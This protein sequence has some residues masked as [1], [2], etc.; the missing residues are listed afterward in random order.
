MANPI[1]Q[2]QHLYQYSNQQAAIRALLALAADGT[3]VQSISNNVGYW[4]SAGTFTSIFTPSAGAFDPRV[5]VSRDYGFF[6]TGILADQKKW[7]ST[8]GFSK[9]GIAA[10]LTAPSVAA[11]S[12]STD[13]WLALVNYTTFGLLTDSNNNIQQL[14]SINANGSNPT[15]VQHTGTSGVGGPAWAA[16]GSTTSDNGISWLNRGPVALWT[17]NTAYKNTHPLTTNFGTVAEPGVIYDPGTNSIY[18]NNNASG[19]PGTSGANRP[20]FTGING[21]IIA[22]NGGDNGTGIAWRCIN[23]APSEWQNSHAYT[24]YASGVS[25][26][27]FRNTTITEPTSAAN[28]YNSVTGAFTA[29]V[30]FQTVQTAGT[31]AA[32]GTTPPWATTAGGTTTDGNLLWQCE[33][34]KTWVAATAYTQW[35][36]NS[37]PF[38]V[39]LDTNGNYQVCF[40]SGTSGG[41]QP[42]WL[43]NYGDQTS[44]NTVIW[45]NVGP[46]LTW[47]ASTL[48]YMGAS[49]WR[50][51]TSGGSFAGATILDSNGD[52]E[53]VISSGKSETPGP[54]TW[55]GPGLKTTD[56]TVTWYNLGVAPTGSGQVTLITPTGRQYYLIFNNPNSGGASDVS[57]VSA[58]TGAISG[59]EIF[60]SQLAVSTDPQVSTKTI[61]ATADGGDQTTLFQIATI[62]NAQTTYVDTLSELLR[63][64]QPV[65]QDTDNAGVSH[66][67]F[68]N[69]PPPNGS[70]PIKYRGRLYMILGTFLFFSKSLSDMITSTGLIAGRYEEC[71]PSSYQ[72]DI[73]EN[74]EVGRGLFTDGVVLY[75]G[76]QRHIRKIQG[77]GP[78]GPNAFT[79]PEIVFNEVGIL[80]Q[81]VWQGIFLEGS[82]AGAMWLTP[83]FRCIRSDF[84]TYSNAGETIQTTL[85][86]INPAAA[87]KSWATYVGQGGYNFYVLAIPTGTNNFPDTLC[88]YNIATG[89][90]FI[91]TPADLMRC[92]LY[93]ANLTGIPRWLVNTLDGS[94]YLFDPTM[95]MDRQTTGDRVGITTTIRT[96]FNDLTDSTLR[97]ALNEIEV[98]TTQPL[99][100]TV[101]GAS[102]ESTFLSP[103]V[104]VSGASLIQNIFGDQKLYLTGLPSFDRL[105]R[106]TFQDT[107]TI[108]SSINDV[109]L[110]YYSMEAIPLH[111]N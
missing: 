2:A 77:D 61:L 43:T 104:V 75:I 39:I 57:P 55:S 96:S 82:P 1:I 110:S 41:S 36:G 40:Q 42:T 73:S 19:N 93:Y 10:P 18:F 66:G 65:W 30:F 98:A 8:F 31:S 54:P 5:V 88:V 94:I 37:Q 38:S 11:T 28:A 74:T 50:I 46:A 101:E 67:V 44:D 105:Y 60:L 20:A 91:W 17:P 29:T 27:N 12:G 14:Q 100:L 64:A 84:N 99:T 108:N 59:G 52:L 51:P 47:A 23:P 9:W 89:R 87:S 35:L 97:K 80:N 68:F 53:S 16:P 79:S 6:L 63:E 111:R 15:P 107:S 69:D 58:G 72:L 26:N 32:S 85:N 13:T 56:G 33:G 34:S 109:I 95:T 90:W 62:P 21:Q 83:D 25:I 102:A 81:D 3:G 48:W 92:G 76:T 4:N 86:S 22:D 24:T 71:W 45:V 106:I 70:F 49:G 103:N 7:N 78:T